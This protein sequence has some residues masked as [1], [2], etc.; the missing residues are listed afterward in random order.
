MTD[1][2]ILEMIGRLGLAA[3]ELVLYAFG[4]LHLVVIVACIFGGG[5][6]GT[7]HTEHSPKQTP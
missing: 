4:V 7:P 6:K 2:S 3:F 5:D 1:V